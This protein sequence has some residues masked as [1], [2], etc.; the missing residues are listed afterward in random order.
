MKK[1]F[2]G[3]DVKGGLVRCHCTRFLDFSITPEKTPKKKVAL[4][5][6]HLLA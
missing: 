6:R 2:C 3:N 1:S 5:K 4:Q